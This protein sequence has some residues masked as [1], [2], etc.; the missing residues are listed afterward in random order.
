M[1]VHHRAP[2]PKQ[3]LVDNPRNDGQERGEQ[4]DPQPIP[5]SSSDTGTSMQDIDG[6]DDIINSK[7]SIIRVNYSQR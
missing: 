2:S 5:A 7:I 6:D 1:T 4:V 3:E